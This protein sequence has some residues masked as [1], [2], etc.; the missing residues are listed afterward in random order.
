MNKVK[1]REKIEAKE[2]RRAREKEINKVLLDYLFQIHAASLKIV[3]NPS[4]KHLDKKLS[5]WAAKVSAKA[6]TTHHLLNL[7]YDLR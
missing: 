2:K 3:S 4:T 1:K 5:K 6:L 7:Q